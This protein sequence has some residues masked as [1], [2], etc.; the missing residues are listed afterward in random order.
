MIKC[1][2]FDLAVFIYLT[3]EYL[4]GKFVQNSFLNHTFQRPCA[5]LRIITQFGKPVQC[6]R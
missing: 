6:L 1:I 2:Q 4:F 3:G 5:K